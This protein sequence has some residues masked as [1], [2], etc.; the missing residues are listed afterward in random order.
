[1]PWPG[2]GTIHEGG[3]RALPFSFSGFQDET[4]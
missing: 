1:V 3:W 2:L 4:I